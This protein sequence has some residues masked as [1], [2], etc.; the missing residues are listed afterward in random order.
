MKDDEGEAGGGVART[1]VF[2]LASTKYLL[3]LGDVPLAKD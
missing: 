3:S 1:W 2:V